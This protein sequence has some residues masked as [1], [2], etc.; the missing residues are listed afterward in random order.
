MLIDSECNHINGINGDISDKRSESFGDES[1]DESGISGSATISKTL[2]SASLITQEAAQLL[3]GVDGNSLEAK[4]KT[5]LEDRKTFL[6]DINHLKN[7][8]EDERQRST[9]LEELTLAQSSNS[10]PNL[11]TKDIQSIISI[12]LAKEHI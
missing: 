4:I 9:K 7:E 12:M 11:D 5:L 10:S 8:L 6:N 2:P 3:T 1:G